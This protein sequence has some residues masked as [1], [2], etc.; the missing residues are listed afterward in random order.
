MLGLAQ[1]KALD[2]TIIKVAAAATLLYA[3]S[4]VEFL[5]N[6]TLFLNTSHG[7]P[8]RSEWIMNEF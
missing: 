5:L 4:Y 6:C 2:F 3:Y 1:T 8:L 7:G